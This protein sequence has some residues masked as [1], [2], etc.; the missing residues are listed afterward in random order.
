MNKPSFTGF[1]KLLTVGATVQVVGLTDFHSQMSGTRPI[2]RLKTNAMATRAVRPNGEV[3]EE[4]WVYWPEAKF[5][6]VDP[7]GRKVTLRDPIK[8]YAWISYEVVG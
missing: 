1:K 2:T 6:D 8:N 3:V 4:S 7:S 5:I